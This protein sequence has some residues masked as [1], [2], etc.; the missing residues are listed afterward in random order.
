MHDEAI[1]HGPAQAQ[2]GLQYA[3]SGLVSVKWRAAEPVRPRSR[4]AFRKASDQGGTAAVPAVRDRWNE[5]E[6]VYRAY[7]LN[8]GRHRQRQYD[9]RRNE[10]GAGEE[11]FLAKRAMRGIV[12]R[13]LAV[14]GMAGGDFACLGSGRRMDVSLGGVTGQRERHQRQRQ[15]GAPPQGCGAGSYAWNSQK[16]EHCLES[17]LMQP[18]PIKAGTASV[19]PREVRGTV[20]V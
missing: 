9:R 20:S 18:P 4:R 13:R 2:A 19:I 10:V 5:R 15:Y 8:F 11:I 6:I 14:P 16:P 1:L 12:E 17:P 3:A 7:C